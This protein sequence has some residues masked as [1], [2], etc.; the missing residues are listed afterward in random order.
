MIISLYGYKKEYYATLN[1]DIMQGYW[2]KLILPH[3]NN[4]KY[5]QKKI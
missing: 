5:L 3:N 4:K 2:H 1:Y